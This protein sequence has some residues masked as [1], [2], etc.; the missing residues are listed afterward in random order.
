MKGTFYFVC[1]LVLQFAPGNKISAQSTPWYDPSAATHTYCNPLN[2]A[3]AYEYFNQNSKE[4]PYRSSADPV[5]VAF[6]G[7][8]YLFCTNQSGYFV[9]NDFNHWQLIP[10]PLQRKPDD[11][12]QCAP[13]VFISG[14]TLFYAGS[15]YE[16]LPIWYT[17]QPRSGKWLHKVDS[18]KLPAWDPCYFVD[19]DGRLYMYYGSSGSRPIKGVEVN[20]ETFL[21][22]GNPSDYQ[23]I[24]Q[25]SELEVKESVAGNIHEV[26]A[27]HPDM[28]GWERFGMNNDDPSPAWGNFIEGAWMTKYK[29][30]YYLQYAAPGTEF[31]VYAD[32]VLV[33]DTP[34]GPFVYQKSNPASYK[35]GGFIK[36]A[37]HGNTFTDLYGNYWHTGTCMLS[38]KN[39]FERRIGLYPAAFDDQNTFHVNTAYGDFPIRVPQRPDETTDHQIA[40]MLLSYAKPMSASHSDAQHTAPLA[41]DEDIQT[42]WSAGSNRPGEWL[43]VDLGQPMLVNALQINFADD[44]CWQWGRAM[45]IYH[46]YRIYFSTDSVSWQLLVDK[47]QAAD[48]VPHDYIELSRQAV[49]RYFRIENV[50]M[51]A[52]NFAISDFRLFGFGNGPRP[53][54]PNAFEVQR[55]S[56][57]RDASLQWCGVPNAVGYQIYFGLSADKPYHCI[58]VY[59]PATSYELRG[60]DQGT[61]YFF[62]IEC[63]NESG[64]SPQ[65]Q[66]VKVP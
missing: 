17:L 28:H 36:G 32:G 38:V 57:P 49:G 61:S 7:A 56:D 66:P 63:F 5:I 33:G 3:Y 13:A 40:W 18:T 21:P 9:S 48:D 10:S 19:D 30:K 65:S 25:S 51:P 50:H 4:G 39:K 43:Q 12:D 46:Q 23:K 41:A 44:H 35:P 54:T 34:M 26:A 52:G 15:T 11:D 14:D 24:Y 53:A 27:L 64:I 37:G 55:H 62:S 16:S 60:L 42:W 1:I 6:Q 31:K 8:Y 45:D 2:I 29:G 59:A 22:S 47:S 58:T 20:R